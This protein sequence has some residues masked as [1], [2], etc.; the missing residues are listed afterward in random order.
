MMYLPNKPAYLK[1]V[2]IIKYQF[3][4]SSIQQDPDLSKV[5]QRSN[6]QSHLGQ[7]YSNLY[8]PA[9]PCLDLISTAP[10]IPST[11]YLKTCQSL[12]TLTCLASGKRSAILANDSSC[13]RLKG[14]GNMDSGF[15]K[16]LMAY[17][18]SAYEIRGCCFLNTVIREQ[19][20]TWLINENLRN[21]GF[22]TGNKAKEYWKY[23]ES[24]FELIEKFCGV[25]ETFGEKRLGSH[26]I[27]GLE[28]MVNKFFKD[29]PEDLVLDLMPEDRRINFSTVKQIKHTGPLNESLRSWT[30][31]GVYKDSHLFV[32]ILKS[33]P[34]FFFVPD[35]THE[36]QG[37][38]IN[39]KEIM[40]KISKISYRIGWEAGL[41]KRILQDHEISWGYFIDHNPFE[42]HCNAHCNNFLVLGPGNSNLL[43][44]VDFDMAFRK[45]EFVSLIEGEFYGKFDEQ[46]FENWVN[47]ERINLEL[48]LAG[49]ENMANFK[50]FNVSTSV[51]Q[52]LFKDLMV[53]G[54]REGFEKAEFAFEWKREE[55]EDVLKECLRFTE[56][57]TEY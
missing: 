46:L 28:L 48:T 26:L 40:Q 27:V 15:A 1:E 13:L 7:D 12:S 23:R 2:E 6:P 16:E 14:C 51:V 21:F 5:L 11:G 20:L 44:P 55:F 47:C 30:E 36:I 32:N 52:T 37:Q 25:F 42:P 54:F 33:S 10:G 39:S 22:F 50:Y 9:L 45:E 29:L 41:I 18:E 49:Q 3:D 34:D 38:T 53:V 35:Q 4:H 43:A 31:Q 24:D 8:L 57:V 19:Y 56:E 17:P